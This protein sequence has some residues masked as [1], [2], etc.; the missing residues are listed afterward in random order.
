MGAAVWVIFQR[1]QPS[2]LNWHGMCQVSNVKDPGAEFC[3]PEGKFV[4]Y[5]KYATLAAS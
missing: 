4:I 5:L 1:M 3:S 2:E